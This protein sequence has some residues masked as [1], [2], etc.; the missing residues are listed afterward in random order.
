LGDL[1]PDILTPILSV[2]FV[3]CI[4]KK[5]QVFFKKENMKKKSNTKAYVIIYVPYCSIH[6]NAQTKTVLP[7]KSVGR[8]LDRAAPK[9][10]IQIT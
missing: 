7:S 2:S 9:E 6:Q 8:Q 10:L 5:I 3:Q 4:T 1:T